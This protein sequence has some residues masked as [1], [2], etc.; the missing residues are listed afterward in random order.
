MVRFHPHESTMSLKNWHD[1]NPVAP[2]ANRKEGMVCVYD[3]G[4]VKAAYY[5]S[6]STDNACWTDGPPHSSPPGSLVFVA[7][8]HLLK[9]GEELPD[10]CK[11]VEQRRQGTVV[12]RV[13]PFGPPSAADWRGARDSQRP[14]FMIE[15][16]SV[17]GIWPPPDSSDFRP[18]P[19]NPRL[20]LPDTSLTNPKIKKWPRRQATCTLVP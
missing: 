5:S 9:P 7:H 19:T 17:V 2:A 12:K 16:D 6:A 18:H 4:G 20:V 3:S 1:A 14:E 10:A 8:P 15:A 13:T 11:T